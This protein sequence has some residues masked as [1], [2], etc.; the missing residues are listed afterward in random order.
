MRAS[1]GSVTPITA[2]DAPSP[3]DQRWFPL[4]LLDG[5]RYLFL[6]RRG[7]GAPYVIRLGQIDST[8][9]QTLVESRSPGIF[10]APGHLLR[11]REGTLVAHAFDP[12]TGALSGNPVPIIDPVKF[13]AITYQ[14]LMS[15]SRTGRLAYQS[16]VVQSELIWYSRDGKRLN[17]A[18][19]AGGYNTIC[20]MPDERRLVYELADERTGNVDVWTRN[21]DGGPPSR[22]TFDAGV[23][24]YPVCP[25]NGSDIVFS[26]LREVP[27]NLLKVRIDAP[28]TESV[29]LRSQQP[30]IATE[31]SREGDL[32]I[33]SALRAG[34]A[35]DIFVCLCRRENPRHLWRRRP[36]NATPDC[37]LMDAGSPTCRMSPAGS[38]S[39]CSPFLQQARGGRC[40][41]MAVSSR[42]RVATAANST[43]WRWI[44]NLSLSNSSQWDP[45]SRGV[46]RAR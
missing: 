26:T 20:I 45:Y 27:P 8:E 32:L 39:T 10:A 38:R 40:H 19:G 6:G 4:F 15:V 29:L 46:R 1:G 24:F 16:T 22:L 34:T 36:K 44:R 17:A 14:A 23:D 3:S 25:T 12:A 2:P 31:L 13:N 42:S 35:W 28:G 37:P 21:V 11:R 18:A 9:T 30:K 41:P 33:Y 7:P 43:M 5:K